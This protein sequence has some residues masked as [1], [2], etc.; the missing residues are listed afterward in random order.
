MLVFIKTP[1]VKEPI[2][3]RVKE[4]LIIDSDPR[5]AFAQGRSLMWFREW[6]KR[7]PERG[8]Y[9]VSSRELSDSPPINMTKH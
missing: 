5:L 2:G 9:E 7:R 3:V 8:W 1:Y 6:L 4:G